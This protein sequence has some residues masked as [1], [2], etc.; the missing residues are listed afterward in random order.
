MPDV[1]QRDVYDG[2]GPF[3]DLSGNLKEWVLDL[4]S[5]FAHQENG[6][7]YCPNENCLLTDNGERYSI[8]GSF[9]DGASELRLTQGLTPRATTSSSSEV[10]FR[11][12]FSIEGDNTLT[13]LPRSSESE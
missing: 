11:C 2:A 13:G 10:G 7:P 12:F 1:D 4:S 9:N 6:E 8:G 5:G 3:C